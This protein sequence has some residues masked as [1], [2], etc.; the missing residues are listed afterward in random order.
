MP[1]A[2]TTGSFTVYMHREAINEISSFVE[3]QGYKS[4]GDYARDLIQRDMQEKGHPIDFKIETWGRHSTEPQ[5][6]TSSKPIRANKRIKKVA[7]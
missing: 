3:S 1:K 4:M 7:S 6:D 5:P 2:D